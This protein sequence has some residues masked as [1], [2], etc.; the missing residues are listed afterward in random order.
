MA[1]EHADAA[2]LRTRVHRGLAWKLASQLVVQGSRFVVVLVI[3]RF[4]TPH[5]YGLAG[6]ALVFSTLVFVFADLALGSAL[7]QRPEIDEHDRSTVFWAT[8]AAGVVLTAAGF[9]LAGP[10]AGFY[11]EPAVKPLYEALSVGFVL[12]ALGSTHAALMTRAMNFRGLELRAIGSTL[13]G[14]SVAVGAAV[15]GLG[16]WSIILMQLATTGTSTVLL[17]CFSGW[18][19]RI[20]F[21][22]RSVRELGGFGANVFGTRLLFYLNR[23]VDNLLI[24]RVLGAA[25]LGVYSLAYNVMLAPLSRVAIP[26]QH[27]LYPAFA[28]LREDPPRLRSA[29][30]RSTRLLVAVVAPICLGLVVIAPDFVSVFFGERWSDATPV[31]QILSWVALLQAASTFGSG[32]LQALDRAQALLRFAVVSFVVYLVAFLLGLRWGIVGVAACYAIAATVAVQPLYLR[33]VT[34]ALGLSTREL[35]RSLS[36]VAQVCAALL[37]VEVVLRQAL[38][39][40]GVPPALRLAVV[41][42]VAIVLFLPLCSWRAHEV[43]EEIRVLRPRLRSGRS[44]TSLR[45]GEAL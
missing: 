25:A 11:R 16:A 33:V 31:I 28:R 20:A 3:A 8:V 30:L 14:A 17:W 18:H 43:V 15:G 4:L 1:T 9:A 35:C 27:V 34:R 7:I 32:I 41:V 13:L 38:V 45:A 6:M 44:R 12:G 2:T 36:G 22:L 10:I 42:G 37:V 21:S 19:P 40:S 39:Q 23:N 26:V 29:W 24:G 5:E